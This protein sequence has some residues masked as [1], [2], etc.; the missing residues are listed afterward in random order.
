M[1]FLRFAVAASLLV[2]SCG[3]LVVL[4]NAGARAIHQWLA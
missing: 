3:A 1:A 4:G 2:F